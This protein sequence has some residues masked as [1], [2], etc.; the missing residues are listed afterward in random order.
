MITKSKYNNK[1]TEID[2]HVFDSQ[3]EARYYEQVK[4]LKA[5]AE[6]QSFRLQPRYILQ[7]AFSKH[8]K[9]HRK[10]EYIADFEIVHIDK[11][12]EVVDVKGM[13]TP[14]FAIKRKLFEKKYPF[15]LSLITYSKIDGGWIDIDR[16]MKN[17]KA[18]K[19]AKGVVK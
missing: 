16:L 17:R 10:I 9:S 15:K 3:I 14:D 4:W 6:I 13:I 12:I 1:K 8:G 2:G 19:K 11:E 18:R 7:D 5:N